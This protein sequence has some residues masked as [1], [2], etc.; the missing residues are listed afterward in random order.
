MAKIR[1]KVAAEGFDL[2][3]REIRGHVVV[4]D[5]LSNKVSYVANTC[6]A[7][8]TGASTPSCRWIHF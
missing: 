1:Q 6:G 3:P 8:V 4:T 5:V 2:P 7:T